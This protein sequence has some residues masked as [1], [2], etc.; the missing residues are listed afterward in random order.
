MKNKFF[1]IPPILYGD[2]DSCI[3]LVFNTNNS[4]DLYDYNIL[5]FVERIK[6]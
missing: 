2:T 5:E 3:V 6:Y 1:E 4:V